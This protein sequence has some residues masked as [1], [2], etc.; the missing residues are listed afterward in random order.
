[1][2]MVV[3]SP[4]P[5]ATLA[6]SVRAA[7]QEADPMMPTGDCRTLE[8]VVD[9]S[10]SPRRFILVLVAAFAGTGLALAALGIYAVLS[11]LVGQRI[12]EIGIRMALGES[13]A[14]VLRR[15]VG[16]T[17]VL[18]LTGVAIGAAVGIVVSHLM[19]SLLYGIGSSDV[20][21]FAGVAFILLSASA[22]A[23]FLPAWQASRTD[24]IEALRTG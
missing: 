12:P 9:R 7:L 10:I 1:M 23:S 13:A 11:F 20:P 3:R 8:S 18:A 24:P 22:A 6:P 21:T 19:Q 16:R 17:M 15:V 4:L 14:H 5:L 2:T